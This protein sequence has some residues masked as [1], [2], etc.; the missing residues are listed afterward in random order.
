VTR[1]NVGC[2]QSPTAGWTNYDNSLSA[3]LARVPLVSSLV[4]QVGVLTKQQRSFMEFARWHDIRYANVVRRI[5]EPTHAATV[6]YTSHMVEHLRR[7]E[8]RGFLL[9]ARR[10]LAR[11]GILRIAVP[12]VRYHV[13]QYI[14]DD[15]ADG[16]MARL[17][18]T[19]TRP[20][21]W[22]GMMASWLVGDRQH[23][24]MY[25]GKSLCRLVASAGFE[26]A[27]VMASGT[28]MIPDPGQLNLTERSPESVFVEARNP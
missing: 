9:E 1:L 14:S 20:G 27:Q 13:D 15:D 23:Q 5:P 4:Q 22:S 8:V 6:L 21:T 25:D 19:R 18:V 3:R 17:Y 11:G 26:S 16:L 7:D 2:G 10:V 28:T 24:W 12:D